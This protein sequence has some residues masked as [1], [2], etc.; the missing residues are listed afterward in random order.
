MTIGICFGR[1]VL[2]PRGEVAGSSKTSSGGVEQ[3]VGV[4]EFCR[5][6]SSS[7]EGFFVGLESRVRLLIEKDLAFFANFRCLDDVESRGA[8]GFFKA[9]CS[10]GILKLAQKGCV[11]DGALCAANSRGKAIFGQQE[12]LSVMS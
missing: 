1:V 12:G 11:S 3:G 5:F 7:G 6:A 2:C 8:S 4:N 10:L 9:S